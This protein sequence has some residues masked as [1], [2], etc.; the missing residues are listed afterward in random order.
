VVLIAGPIIIE[1]FGTNNW[2]S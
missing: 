1:M 2:W